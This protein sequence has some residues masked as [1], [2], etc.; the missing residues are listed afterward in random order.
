MKIFTNDCG[1]KV[2]SD[3]FVLSIF[4]SL[5]KSLWI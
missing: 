5:W 2:S 3:G 4:V 1:L